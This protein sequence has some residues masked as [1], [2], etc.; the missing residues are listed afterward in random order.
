M[1]AS[2][3]LA[4]IVMQQIPSNVI[5]DADIVVPIPLH[6]TRYAQRGYNQAKVLATTMAKQY[7]RPVVC[8]LKR[9]KRTKLQ[10]RLSKHERQ[11]N[12]NQAFIIRFRHRSLINDKHIVLVDDL[13]TT[14]STVM[15]AAKILFDAGARRITVVVG[16]RKI[17]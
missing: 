11:Q 3:Y 7:N 16:A 12:L 14:G 6:W 4:R 10:A 15:N 1:V 8:V 2:F 9:I 5:N 17:D 13:Y